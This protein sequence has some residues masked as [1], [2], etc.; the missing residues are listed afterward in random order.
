M[1]SMES[2][3]LWSNVEYGVMWTVESWSHVESCGVRSHVDSKVMWSMESCGLWS[4]VD[5]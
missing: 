3:G 5:C 1:W 4:H 2:C